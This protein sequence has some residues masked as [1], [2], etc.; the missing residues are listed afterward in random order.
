MKTEK[1]EEI[2][3]KL[4]RAM[5]PTYKDYV[6]YKGEIRAKNKEEAALGFMDS[7][8][9]SPVAMVLYAG[10]TLG[11]KY[12]I[13]GPR[14]RVYRKKGKESIYRVCLDLEYEEN[15]VP[16]L[17]FTVYWDIEVVR[18]GRRKRRRYYC[19]LTDYGVAVYKWGPE[20]I[21]PILKL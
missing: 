9:S 14:F 21:R 10:P 13:G 3:K 12:P 8:W 6:G 15:Y 17:V 20:N 11:L 18:R 2:A 19:Q 5:Q 16:L 7:I 4:L 1:I